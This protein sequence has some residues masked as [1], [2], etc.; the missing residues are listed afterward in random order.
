[1]EG[2]HFKTIGF[3]RRRL[4]R[5]VS[6]FCLLGIFT[7]QSVAQPSISPP[8]WGAN[9]N[10][11]QLTLSNCSDTNVQYIIQ[12][13]TNL[14]DWQT[15]Q[16]YSP[17]ISNFLVMVTTSNQ[18]CFYR[19]VSMPPP[20]AYSNLAIFCKTNFDLAGENCTLDSFDSSTP[21]YSTVG[22]YDASKRKAN[23]CL[24]TDASL[25]NSLNVGDAN[26][27]GTIYTGVGT[28]ANSV[29]VKNG[30]VGDLNWV[31]GAAGIQPGHWVG[32]LAEAIPDVA[33][34][35]TAG[36]TLFLPPA[37]NGYTTLNGGNYV[38]NSLNYPLNVT[39]PT[40]LWVKGAGSSTIS[41]GVSITN[42]GGALILYVGNT[43]GSATSLKFNGQGN[44]N[45]NGFPANFQI[46]GL[47][48]LTNVSYTGNT[49]FAGTIYAPEATVS[50]SGGGG[51]QVFFCGAIV[52]KAAKLESGADVHF[53]E[54]LQMAGPAFVN[55]WLFLPNVNQ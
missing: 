20:I 18:S 5:L 44:M 25:V 22:I 49:N 2:I 42:A 45:T 55:G 48:S 34:P 27:Y 13:S 7:F 15:I 32:N 1:M 21:L 33:A 36:W 51:T 23:M 37:T 26:V 8:V 38:V 12:M 24:A 40:T 11:A 28:T 54:S 31:P 29:A 4:V 53:D 52:A 50:L 47:S 16:A 14:T 3:S 41:V 19:V 46:Y 35:N 39:G 10:Q 6:V 43:N 9:P 30:S 17:S